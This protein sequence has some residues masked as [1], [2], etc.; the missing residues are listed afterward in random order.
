MQENIFIILGCKGNKILSNNICALFTTGIRVLP[1]TRSF[2]LLLYM[3]EK[4]DES[5]RNTPKTQAHFV[6]YQKLNNYIEIKVIWLCFKISATKA[7]T[8]PCRKMCLFFFLICLSIIT[9]SKQI[10]LNTQNLLAIMS[11][12]SGYNVP[13]I[14]YTKNHT[15]E[16]LAMLSSTCIFNIR[17]QH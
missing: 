12:F 16:S 3:R 7:L 15:L 9:C 1:Q 4:G 10:I 11:L 6:S 5:V 13:L 2:T 17:G 14:S 8:I